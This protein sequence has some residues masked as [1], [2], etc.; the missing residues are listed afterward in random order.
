LDKGKRHFLGAHVKKYQEEL[1]RWFKKNKWEYWYQLAQ[2]ARLVEETGELA[3]ILNHLYGE[4][5]KKSNEATQE[6]EEEIGDVIYTLICLA[7]STGIDLD[8]AIRKSMDKVTK[9]DKNRY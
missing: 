6:L 3:R 7:N 5:P 4:K 9:R 2:F 8:K 1:D